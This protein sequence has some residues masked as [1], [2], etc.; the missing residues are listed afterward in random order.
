MRDI[1][2]VEGCSYDAAS[3][4]NMC[5]AVAMTRHLIVCEADA[6]SSQKHVRFAVVLAR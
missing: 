1:T 3:C 2:A 6:H 4:R 5:M